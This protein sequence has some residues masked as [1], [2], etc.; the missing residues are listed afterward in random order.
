MTQK[1][2]RHKNPYM[3]KVDAYMIPKE[4][5]P[6]YIQKRED[7]AKKAAAVFS[8]YCA[9]VKR[10]WAGSEDGEAITGLNAQGELIMMIHLDPN[11]IENMENA[12]KQ[13]QLHDFLLAWN[14]F[15]PKSGQ[16]HQAQQ[17]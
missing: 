14:E 12:E 6:L 17:P 10:Q 8:Q 16:N 4:D 13:G 3:V 1:K 9:E 2:R 11:G 15:D 7:Y 5:A